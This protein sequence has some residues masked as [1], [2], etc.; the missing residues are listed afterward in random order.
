MQNEIKGA[1]TSDSC[2]EQVSVTS[3]QILLLQLKRVP[4]GSV[5]HQSQHSLNV[6]AAKEQQQK[7]NKLQQED[8][9]GLPTEQ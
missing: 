2:L 1:T 5:M 7:R 8:F 3:D 4:I 6:I 9:R